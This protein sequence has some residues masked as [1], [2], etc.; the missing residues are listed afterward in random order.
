MLELTCELIEPDVLIP[1]GPQR[2]ELRL[3]LVPVLNP[4]SFKHPYVIDPCN[5]GVPN[6]V[7]QLIPLRT[8]RPLEVREVPHLRHLVAIA[9]SQYF[10]NNELALIKSKEPQP[11]LGK[12]LRL[13]LLLPLECFLDLVHI[14]FQI[15]LLARSRILR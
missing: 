9:I 6:N 14:L 1:L 5:L 8:G 11:A 12:G 13:P 3:E 4:N 15:P 2:L 7:R 10:D